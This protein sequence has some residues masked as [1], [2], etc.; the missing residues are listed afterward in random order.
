MGKAQR[1]KGLRGENEVRL[2]FAAAGLGIVG[3]DRGGDHVVSCGDLRL[4]LE[5]KRRE[6]I[7]V[8][9]WSRQAEREAQPGTIPIVPF[10]TNREP[11]RVSLRLHDFVQILLC[12]AQNAAGA[13]EWDGV[14]PA[15]ELPAPSEKGYQ[16]LTGS[17]TESP[18]Q[19]DQIV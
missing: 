1:D 12:V 10:R 9:E 14:P 13:T 7:R 16:R 6:H 4:H 3:V 18:A 17:P 8:L 2:L 5:V 19:P 11:W 15:S